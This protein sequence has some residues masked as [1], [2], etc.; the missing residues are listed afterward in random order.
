[1]THETFFIVADL[2]EHGRA[3]VETT[4]GMT[5]QEAA[6]L[7]ITGEVTP[8]EVYSIRDGALRLGVTRENERI[9]KIVK[10]AYDDGA[11]VA[12]TA[13]DWAEE[14][15]YIRQPCAEDEDY[16]REMAARAAR[17]DA[18]SAIVRTIAEMS[19]SGDA[20]DF[21]PP[22]EHDPDDAIAT[23]DSLIERA[24]DIMETTK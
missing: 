18:A 4:V 21:E 6:S 22:Y 14:H 12:E 23:L 15:V 8:I 20:L 1:M 10:A 11:N 24:R 9:A 3:I 17:E 5:A 2:G 19:A 7:I 16:A 13:L